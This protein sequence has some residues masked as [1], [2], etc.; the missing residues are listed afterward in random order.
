VISCNLIG[1]ASGRLFTIFR[2]RAGELFFWRQTKERR[3]FSN[4]KHYPKNRKIHAIDIKYCKIQRIYFN[5]FSTKPEMY[6][7]S[8][9]VRKNKCKHRLLHV[10]Y[11]NASH[12]YSAILRKFSINI[13]TTT[14]NLS[15]T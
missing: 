3:Q 11:S 10:F 1:Y 14:Y 4:S 7:S 2:P 12:I 8:T 6:F 15:L 13:N 5:G 9:K